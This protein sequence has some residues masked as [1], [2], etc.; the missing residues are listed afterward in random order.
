MDEADAP[1]EFLRTQPQCIQGQMRPY[2][3]GGLN[4]MIRLRANGLNGI[5]AD[6]MGLG[7]T[8]QAISMLG[9]LHECVGVDG[10]HLVL[11]RWPRGSSF[12]EESRRR[13]GRDVDTA[14]MNRGDA[15]AATW[16]FLW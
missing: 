14:L 5:L 8:L 11:V 3:L 12:D 6:E 13:R 10:P 16:I 15:A 7:K 9:Y 2:Q 4:W 1:P